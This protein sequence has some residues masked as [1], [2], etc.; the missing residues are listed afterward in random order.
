MLLVN[1][2]YKY[3]NRRYRLLWRNQAL[4]YWID[5]DNQNA[6]PKLVNL[7]QLT[8]ALGDNLI[9]YINDPYE[10]FILSPTNESKWAEEIQ[11][12][13]WLMIKEHV[14]NE[15]EIYERS[16]RGKIIQQIVAQNETT[17]ALVYRK[18]RLYWQR[19]K[20]PNALYPDMSK[21][22][23]P[24]QEKVAG[25]KKRGRPRTTAIGTGVNIN[26]EIASVFRSVIK[27]HYLTTKNKSITHTYNKGLIALGI[28]P[29]KVSEEELAEAPTYEQFYHFLQKEVG[30]VEK[31]R[32]RAGEI[33]YQKD[34]RPVLGTS[35]TEAVGPGSL[36]QIDATI[37]DIYLV[38]ENDRTKIIGRPVIYIVVDVFS[39]LVTGLY[40]GL[41]GPSWVSAMIALAN[42]MTDKV[43]YCAKYGISITHEMWPV[44]G[45]PEAIL[46][47][48]GEL[49]SKSIEVLSNALF[50]DIANTPAYRADW[51]GIV[52]RHFMTLHAKFR[53]YAEGYVTGAIGKKRAGR[54][55]RLDAELTLNEITRIIIYCVLNYNTKHVMDAYDADYDIPTELPHN[56]LAL[57]NWGIKNR[58]G[59]LRSVSEE[60]AIVN[61]LPHTEASVTENGIKLFGCFYSTA[62]AIKEGWFDR[63]ETGPKKVSVAYD[64]HTCNTIYLRLD[65]KYDKF[66]VC[67]L[68]ERSREFRGLTFWDVWRIRKY[69][70]ETK[71]LAKLTKRKGDLNLDVQI[72]QIIK[73][74]KAKKPDNLSMPKSER[75]KGIRQNRSDA[76]E[77]NRQK[78]TG[79][80]SNQ[81]KLSTNK[82][83]KDNV[84]YLAGEKPE[85]HSV[86]DMLEE[87]Y[88]DDE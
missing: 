4:V 58:T 32:K 23:A 75:I 45:K 81:D 18:L 49:M 6:L 65:G 41:E 74:A 86:P 20:S 2:V 19:G 56:P 73:E 8:D 28:D 69:K 85:D 7:N 25:A 11:S 47:D 83:K 40:V 66:I 16:Q 10:G 33:I 29:T 46:A 87:L 52:E 43:R 30:V 77:D 27:A 1:D 84:V 79:L 3:G 12:K 78:N 37:G 15:P 80:L 57:W 59:K 26:A 60:L 71:S 51:K 35:T 88:G 24:N 68:T 39:R 38:A 22:G 70:A 17:K 44:I 50:I 64:P 54:D 42:T 62:Y 36:Y 67:E 21:R 13:S 61:L 48:R 72:E 31:V 9:E 5:I 34:L 14:Q 63:I 55:Y 82:N 53:P 76:I